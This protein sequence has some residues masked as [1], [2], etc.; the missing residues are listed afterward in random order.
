MDR[1][2]QIGKEQ[3]ME[4]EKDKVDFL[5]I[6]VRSKVTTLFDNTPRSEWSETV[7]SWK[8]A[9]SIVDD[10]GHPREQTKIHSLTGKANKRKGYWF[11]D[12]IS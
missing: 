3:D 8:K 5:L 11:L 12:I 4:M 9:W 1:E 10:C 2:T 7:R 6:V